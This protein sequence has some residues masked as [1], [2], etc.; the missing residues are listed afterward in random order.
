MQRIV[1]VLLL[2]LFLAVLFCG[3]TF[4]SER[5]GR[6][7]LSPAVC[8]TPG[9]ACD[10]QLVRLIDGARKT[11][12]VA[13]FT[14]TSRPIA[15]ALIRARQRNVKVWVVLDDNQW[16]ARQAQGHRLRRHGVGVRYDRK[17]RIMHN[18][19]L[20]VDIKITATGSY[21][22]TESAQRNNAENILILTDK[23]TARIYADNWGRHWSH[24]V[25]IVE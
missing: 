2:P 6:E 13:A 12:R 15:D 10:R 24:S 4:A 7:S 14:L 18:K 3:G 1:P 8:F 9:S 11:V 23:A 22:Y 25:R 19:F 17:H 21:N 20:V 5:A 16:H